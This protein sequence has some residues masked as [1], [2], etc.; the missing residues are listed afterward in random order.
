[1]AEYRQASS[2]VRPA[3]HKIARRHNA[4]PSVSQ[5]PARTHG[6]R[7]G[8]VFYGEVQCLHGA[9]LTHISR[10]ENVLDAAGRRTNK[11]PAGARTNAPVNMRR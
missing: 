10:D 11:L 8:V 3:P 2:H 7:R 9:C 1:M 4:S 6:P 5:H